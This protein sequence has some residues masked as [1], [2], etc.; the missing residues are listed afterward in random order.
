MAHQYGGDNNP[1]GSGGRRTDEWGNPVGLKDEWGNP[2]PQTGEYGNSPMADHHGIGGTMAGV[3]PYAN[4]TAPSGILGGGGVAGDGYKT[5]GVETGREHHG[6]IGGMLHRSGSSSSSS[7]EDDGEGGRRR[8]K[9]GIKEKIKEKLPG[10][11]GCHTKGEYGPTTGHPS[12]G[13]GGGYGYGGE[14][15]HEKKGFMDKIKEK[16]PGGGH[17]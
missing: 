9:K 6:T 8:K 4:T 16:L 17:H 11:G 15:H 10:S 2:M 13:G 5:H 7:S 14:E 1:Y 3:G 12:A